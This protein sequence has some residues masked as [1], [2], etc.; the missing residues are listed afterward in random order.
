MGSVQPTVAMTQSTP[1]LEGSLPGDFLTIG[2][3][4]PSLPQP[5]P[6]PSAC[7]QPCWF[8]TPW[9]LCTDWL[10]GEV[11]FQRPLTCRPG[12]R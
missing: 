1:G 3:S 5:G 7:L 10:E 9:S 4:T 6:S 11:D 8:W 2:P 12:T